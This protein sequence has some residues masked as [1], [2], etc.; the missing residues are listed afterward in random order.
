M[1]NPWE[2]IKLSDY[3][4]HMKLG[5]VMQLQTMADMMRTQFNSFDVKTAMVLGVAGGN[6]L[7]HVDPTKL[8]K[9]YG[10]DINYDYLKECAKTHPELDGTLECLCRDLT[11]K[12]CELVYA[13]LLIANLLIEY[14]GY[15]C[16]LAAVEKTSPEYISCVIQV[17]IKEGFVS[18][19][20][21]LH[22]FDGLEKVHRNINEDDLTALLKKANYKQI[23][24]DERLLPDGK[25]LLQLDYKKV[26]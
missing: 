3:E 20:P 25:K 14:I 15:D 5:S 1:K 23:K 9:V 19:S 26:D 11:A 2:E 6:G 18:E 13:D 21:Y 12:D 10:V 17:N 16:F 24:R 7:E 4:N 8:K 22:A